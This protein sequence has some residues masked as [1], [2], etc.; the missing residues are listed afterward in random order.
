MRAVRRLTLVP[1]AALLSLGTPAGHPRGKP[2]LCGA[3][4][5]PRRGAPADGA[6][7]GRGGPRE[8]RI[9]LS[10]RDRRRGLLRRCRPF[11]GRGSPGRLASHGR[12][13]HDP[14]PGPVQPAELSEQS[15]DEGRLHRKLGGGAARDIR[16][17]GQLHR[18]VRSPVDHLP[19]GPGLCRQWRPELARFCGSGAAPRRR[20]RSGPAARRNPG[21][22]LRVDLLAGDHPV[23]G[24][25]DRGGTT[26][27]AGSASRGRSSVLRSA[28]AGCCRPRAR[29]RLRFRSRWSRGGEQ[30]ARSGERPP[31]SRTR[32]DSSAFA[33]VCWPRCSPGPV[34]SWQGCGHGAPGRRMG[35]GIGKWRG[36]RS[37]GARDGSSPSVPRP[38]PR[39]SSRWA[40]GCARSSGASNTA[41]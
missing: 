23:G 9:L 35:A 37:L 25:D 3:G 36:G 13:S 11:A 33:A 28:R 4:I 2:P 30:C 40:A 19:A 22:P 27:W 41:S 24:A 38:V 15:R 32:T 1:F 31:P 8:D 5:C 21:P 12:A 29:G 26:G 20:R 6:R 14:N 16:C 18:D 10:H 34:Q 39:S 7:H 17:D